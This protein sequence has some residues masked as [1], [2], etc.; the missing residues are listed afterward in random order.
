MIK[1]H[2]K[3]TL[4]LVFLLII[5]TSNSNNYS[6]T[7]IPDSLHFE[8][9]KSSLPNEWYSNAVFYEIFVRSFYDSNND[10]IGDL[11]GVIEKL[12]YLKELGVKGIWLMPINMNSDGDHGYA[13][14]DY[15]KIAPEYGTIEDFKE[16]I[17]KAHNKGIGIVMD[18][19]INHCSSDNPFFIS[20]L[21][22]SGSPYRDWF[23]WSSEKLYWR[24]PWSANPV[25][26][27]GKDK[28]YYYGL[29]S[30]SMPDLNFKNEQVYR[31]IQQVLTFWLNIGVDGFRFDA[32]THIFE[33]ENGILADLPETIDLFKGIR[34]LVNSYD[35]KYLI[36][37]AGKSEYIGDGTDSL[38]GYFNFGFIGNLTKAIF[39]ENAQFFTEKLQEEYNKMPDGGYVSNV[40]GNH[41]S[42]LG[43]RVATRFKQNPQLLK[44]A[45]TALLTTPGIPFIYYGEE[46][47]MTSNNRYTFDYS[48]RTPMQWNDALHGGFS[49][50]GKISPRQSNKEYKKI[51][52]TEQQQDKTSL[53]SH[54]KQ[55]INLRNNNKAL[56][57]GSINFENINK[58][59]VTFKRTFKN[60]E[61]F[62]IIN[63]S[64][65]P[66]SLP[67]EIINDYS[68]VFSDSK[69]KIKNKSIILDRYSSLIYSRE[70]TN[71]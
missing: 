8:N 30:R 54:Y 51:N 2:I 7:V 13:I 41:D 65:S 27:E 6:F 23:T 50:M 4:I 29:F 16:L 24:Q 66:V 42:F 58:K 32:A 61:C 36:G 47:G 55:L 25:W 48:L 69:Y 20:A 60:N 31:Y 45:A 18:M 57:Q 26:H 33:N 15:M 40:L 19:V 38:H 62:V 10:G 1:S 3:Y 59:L 71:E 56:C 43:P 39:N 53:L 5:F 17:A 28:K 44:I 46:I 12:D 67:L 68:L 34:K 37:E 70:K 49:T 9:K 63:I 64:N 22:S 52:V 14:M 21:N 35:G 11:R